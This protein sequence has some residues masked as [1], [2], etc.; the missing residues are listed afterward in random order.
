MAFVT[1]EKEKIYLFF[2]SD[3]DFKNGFNIFL[4]VVKD[5]CESCSMGFVIDKN[6]LHYPGGRFTLF[7]KA[8]N[9]VEIACPRSIFTMSTNLFNKS[10][11][12]QT[13]DGRVNGFL[14]HTAFFRNQFS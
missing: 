9:I 7:Q 11:L 8:G 6:L 10:E 14:I 5:L 4:S 13:F 1:A 2:N 3:F 12:R